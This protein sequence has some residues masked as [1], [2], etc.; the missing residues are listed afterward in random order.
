MP[1]SVA[2]QILFTVFSAELMRDIDVASALDTTRLLVHRHRRHFTSTSRSFSFYEIRRRP[3]FLYGF[4]F[5]RRLIRTDPLF[6]FA[7][8]SVHHEI[9]T[10]YP[11]GQ[12][13]MLLCTTGHLFT[14]VLFPDS[15]FT[16]FR[17]PDCSNE[18]LLPASSALHK[19]STSPMFVLPCSMYRRRFTPCASATRTASPPCYSASW[20]ITLLSLS[21]L[22]LLH[23]VKATSFPESSCIDLLY[24]LPQFHSLYLFSFSC[25]MCRQKFTPCASAMRTARP[26]CCCPW[27]Q[28]ATALRCPPVESRSTR[29]KPTGPAAPP[30]TCGLRCVLTSPFTPCRV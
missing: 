16:G 3:P 17:Q 6:S 18:T 2:N 14:L 8:C 10:L 22:T 11:Y 28:R 13:A 1:C 7:F 5:A 21:F 24:R 25:S 26:R 20:A 4:Y 15:T 30:S 12:A 9:F 19:A 23:R 27:G 29:P